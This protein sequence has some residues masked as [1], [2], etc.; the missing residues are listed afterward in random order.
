[1]PSVTPVVMRD[2][3]VS[4]PAELTPARTRSCCPSN[5]R[6][7]T[8]AQHTGPLEPTPPRVVAGVACS[9][10]IVQLAQL[11]FAALVILLL[12]SPGVTLVVGELSE[13]FVALL[14]PVGVE[15]EMAVDMSSHSSDTLASVG[16]VTVAA[17]KTP[18]L[19]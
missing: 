4:C 2:L 11:L 15:L 3:G 1:M 9:L 10:S 13:E 16:A 8:R 18:R 17:D 5:S 6:L 19:A 7:A 14:A 12:V